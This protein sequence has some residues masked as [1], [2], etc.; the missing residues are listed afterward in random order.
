M[1]DYGPVQSWNKYRFVQ[2]GEFEND[3]SK[4][5]SSKEGMD[6]VKQEMLTEATETQSNSQSQC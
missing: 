5:M 6:G 3:L 4:M 1:I 2:K